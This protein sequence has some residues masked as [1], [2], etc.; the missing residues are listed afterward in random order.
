MKLIKIIKILYNKYAN[1]L[2]AK[3]TKSYI[4]KVY[5]LYSSN[6]IV[7]MTINYIDKE[8]IKSHNGNRKSAEKPKILETKKVYKWYRETGGY[9]IRCLQFNAIYN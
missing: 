8:L 4:T 7:E 3:L 5:I 1:G 9:F 2:I 6:N